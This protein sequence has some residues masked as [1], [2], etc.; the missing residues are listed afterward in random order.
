MASTTGAPRS[1]RVT[2]KMKSCPIYANHHGR[3]IFD[4][5]PTFR[6]HVEVPPTGRPPATPRG[7]WRSL[8]QFPNGKGITLAQIR[9]GDGQKRSAN[10]RFQSP[11][12]GWVAEVTAGGRALLVTAGRTGTAARWERLGT[13]VGLWAAGLWA[14]GHR[15][16]P[17]MGIAAGPWAAE[18]APLPVW[19][20]GHRCRPLG[21]RAPLPA[22]G[23]QEEKHEGRTAP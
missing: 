13:A 23:R 20:A 14:D 22:P 18:R 17:L 4:A 3:T 15:C 5:A 7:L 19:T 9:E 2:G 21:G 16:R 12:G 8:R 10:G 1:R 11:L 6:R